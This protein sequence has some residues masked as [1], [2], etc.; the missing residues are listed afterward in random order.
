MFY[1]YKFLMLMLFLIGGLLR[2]P[3]PAPVVVVTD[4][5]ST[6]TENWACIRWHESRDTYT[7]AGGG[8][9]QFEDGTWH[10]VTG[11]S[12]EAQNYSPA[13][14]DSAAL[15]LFGMRGWQPWSTA[16]LCGL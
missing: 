12:G 10:A 8:A 4:A 5:T 13:V 14:Q 1:I 6:N 2:A 9:Y 15:K 16:V 11:L 3:A 7:E